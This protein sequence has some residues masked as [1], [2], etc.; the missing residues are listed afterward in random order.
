[1][2]QRTIT[3]LSDD[4]DGKEGRDITTVTF[5]CDGST[6]EIDLSKKNAVALDKLLKPYIDAAHKVSGSN[7]RAAAKGRSRRAAKVDL[8]AVRAW[9]KESGL[10]VAER[11]RISAEV[12]DAYKAA[13]A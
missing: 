12:V 2:A 8:G 1:M 7:G 4:L 13:H 10:T 11:G 6:Y 5:G 3:I 9:A